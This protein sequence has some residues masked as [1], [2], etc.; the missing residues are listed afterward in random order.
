EASKSIAHAYIRQIELATKLIQEAK[1]DFL[2]SAR[3]FHDHTLLQ[4]I[5][6]VG[7]LRAAMLIAIIGDP[8]RFRSR[9][10]VWAYGGLGVVQKASSEHRLEKGRVVRGKQPTGMRLSRTAQPLL[11]KLLRDLALHASIRG[12]PFRKLY[13]AHLRRGARPSIARLSLARKFAAVIFA[14]WRSGTA[15]NERTVLKRKRKRASGRASAQQFS[16]Q[17]LGVDKATALTICRPEIS[18]PKRRRTRAG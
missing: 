17:S 18:I 11:K 14:V 3:E 13:E 15:F 2:A 10:A 12:G 16:H 5:P 8:N 1:R 9:R 6:Q 7:E 4:T